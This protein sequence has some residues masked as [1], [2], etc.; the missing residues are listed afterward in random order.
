[1]ELPGFQMHSFPMNPSVFYAFKDLSFKTKNFERPIVISA[2]ILIR[3]EDDRVLIKQGNAKLPDFLIRSQPS[4]GFMK[5]TLKSAESILRNIIYSNPTGD[6]ISGGGRSIAELSS[7]FSALPM[8]EGNMN[9]RLPII[10]SENIQ[11]EN[12][13]SSVYPVE[14]AVFEMTPQKFGFVFAT[15]ESLKALVA[16]I[17]ASFKASFSGTENKK[18]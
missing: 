4:D 1:M 18:S 3:R 2:E 8:P 13:M 7:I 16:E 9:F 15:S 12:N 6:T 11:F 14:R 17:E 10:V 5:A